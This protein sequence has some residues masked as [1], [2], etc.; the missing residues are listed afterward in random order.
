M[1]P[2]T[3]CTCG[4]RRSYVPP[5]TAARLADSCRCRGAAKTTRN[6]PSNRYLRRR[7][8]PAPAPSSPWVDVTDRLDDLDAAADELAQRTRQLLDDTTQ[9]QAEVTLTPR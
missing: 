9:A 5:A 6:W 2:Q 1:K 4:S 7:L 8:R 3:G